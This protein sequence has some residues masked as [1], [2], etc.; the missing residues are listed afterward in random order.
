MCSLLLS[1]LQSLQCLSLYEFDFFFQLLIFFFLSHN[2]SLWR[3]AGV[4]WTCFIYCKTIFIFFRFF[5]FIGYMF[6][7]SPVNFN[8]YSPLCQ[9]FNHLQ[10]LFALEIIKLIFTKLE[11]NKLATFKSIEL[12][13][14]NYRVSHF[15][16]SH[17]KLE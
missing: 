13:I 16:L 4:W 9:F 11:M 14:H 2:Y 3:H 17:F 6:S 1:P 5:I 7:I 12:I 8:P 15:Y 10:Q